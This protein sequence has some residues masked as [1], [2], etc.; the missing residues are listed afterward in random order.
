MTVPGPFPSSRRAAREAAILA[1]GSGPGASALPR[2]A[3]RSPAARLRRTVF[4]ATVATLLVSGS[5]S[6][7]L[8]VAQ[9]PAVTHAAADLPT[10]GATE[11]P[12]IEATLLPIPDDGLPTPSFEASATGRA[13]C[14]DPAFTGALAA[15]DEQAVI[16][17]TGGAEAFRSAVATGGVPCV[18]LDDPARTWVVVNK[19]RPHVPIDY[20]PAPLAMPEGVRSLSGGALRADAAAALSALV[21]AAR[22]AGVGEL[23]MESGYRSYA[24]QQSTYAGHVADRGVEGADLVSARPGHSEHQSGLGADLVACDGGC[25]TLDD[26]AATPQGAWLAA[27][28][29]EYGWIVRYVEGRTDVTGYMPEPWHLRYIGLELA[30][31]YHDGGWTTLEEFFGLPPAPGYPG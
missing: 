13:L 1:R 21:Q 29:W 5:A 20:S 18:P 3:R 26:L 24:T 19:Q 17:A 14:D 27:H 11:H 10:P 9:P 30:R 2:H 31:A 25:G 23:A 8:A 6:V 7:T 22:D 15:G 16:A 12:P 4:L 28:A